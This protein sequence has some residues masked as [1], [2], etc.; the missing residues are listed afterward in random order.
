MRTFE[1]KF[2]TRLLDNFIKQVTRLTYVTIILLLTILTF[3]GL[4][5]FG[6]MSDK[7]SDKIIGMIITLLVLTV[8]SAIW[9]A[10]VFLPNE[11]SITIDNSALTITFSYFKKS[12]TI[13]FDEIN[14]IRVKENDEKNESVISHK[15]K[16][17][18]LGLNED[19]EIINSISSTQWR[20]IAKENK[21][22]LIVH[23]DITEKTKER[24]GLFGSTYSSGED[25]YIIR[26]NF[27]NENEKIE[28]Q[29]FIE[30]ARGNDLI[31]ELGPEE[32]INVTKEIQPDP[33]YQFSLTTKFG[34]KGLDFID[35]QLLAT[36]EKGQNPVEIEKIS[37]DLKLS[38]KNLNSI[39]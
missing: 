8:G 7:G 9:K 33:K 12:I 24:K 17:N 14:Y 6:T 29:D 35:G 3:I 25:Y 5:V 20:E 26:K 27:K 18:L 39:Q 32:F 10:L 34:T 23:Q 4:S 2:Q 1:N 15:S 30:Y 13:P 28:L 16:E 21:V 37:E 11:K 19:F 22:P 31:T 36:Y 38:F